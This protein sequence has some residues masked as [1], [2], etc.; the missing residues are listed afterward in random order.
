MRDSLADTALPNAARPKHRGNHQYNIKNKRI[1]YASAQPSMQNMS[2]SHLAA[3]PHYIHT[4]NPVQATHPSIPPTLHSSI[5]T[6]GIHQKLEKQQQHTSKVRLE[7]QS[8]DQ[9]RPRDVLGLA[10]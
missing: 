8:T 3:P 7:I 6:R 9:S 5:R 1:K 2:H 4:Y 10:K